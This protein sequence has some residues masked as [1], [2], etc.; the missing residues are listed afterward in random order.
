MPVRSRN[1]AVFLTYAVM[2]LDLPAQATFLMRNYVPNALD[3]PVF[4]YYGSRL[5]GSNYVAVLYGGPAF[6]VLYLARENSLGYPLMTPVPLTHTVNGQGGY[7]YL[8]RDV[9]FFNVDCGGIAWLQVRVWDT[10]LGATYEQVAQLG[11]GGFGESAL[12]QKQGGAPCRLPPTL[13]EPLIGLQS[14]SLVPEPS[15]WTLLA[16]GGLAAWVGRRRHR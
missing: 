15:V 16:L 12:F 9:L 7:F 14:F 1:C 8:G 3:A 11:L 13:P 5:F 2:V 10:E 6:E 4:N